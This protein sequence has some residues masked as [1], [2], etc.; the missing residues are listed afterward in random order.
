MMENLEL[1]YLAIMEI[2]AKE[3]GELNGGNWLAAWMP[4]GVMINDAQF[5]PDNYKVGFDMVYNNWNKLNFL[6]D[7]VIFEIFSDLKY[8][9]IPTSTALFSFFWIVIKRR[10]ENEIMDLAGCFGRYFT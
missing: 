7:C 8:F 1:K 9:I 4:L 2:D 6:L 5:N 10:M 3:L